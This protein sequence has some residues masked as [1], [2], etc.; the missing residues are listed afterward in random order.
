MYDYRPLSLGRERAGEREIVQWY[1]P[2]LYPLPPGA[3][4]YFS[5]IYE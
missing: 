1:P 3:G 4:K 5:I 2:P